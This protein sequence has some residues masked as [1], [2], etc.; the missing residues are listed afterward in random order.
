MQNKKDQLQKL[1]LPLAQNGLF[2]LALT[3]AELAANAHIQ[4]KILVHE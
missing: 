4:K 2:P 3:V 1:T